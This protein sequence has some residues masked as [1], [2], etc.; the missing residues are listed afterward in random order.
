M[1][2]DIVRTYRKGFGETVEGFA[3]MLRVDPRT[4]RRWE[5]GDQDIPKWLELYLPVAYAL[6]EGRERSEIEDMV[7]WP[8]EVRPPN[9]LPV[10]KPRRKA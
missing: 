3:D 5:S 10:C 4:V 7:W 6:V 9:I 8:G 2:P 1:T